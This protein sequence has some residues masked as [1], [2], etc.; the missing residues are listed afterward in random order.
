MRRFRVSSSAFRVRAAE[1]TR[2]S[3]LETRN[4][5]VLILLLLS[6]ICCRQEM[7]DQPKYKDL[8]RSEFFGDKRQARPVPEG[9]VARGFLRADSRVFAG[10]DP[11]G[12]LVTA[13]PMAVDQSLLLRGRQRYDIFCSPCHDRVGT[14][15]GMVVRRG[16]RPPPSLHIARLREAPVG[17]LFDVI[18]N[19]FGAMP[20]YSTQID[21]P[22]RW[23]IVAY[24]RALQLSE[25]APAAELPAEERA[26]LESAPAQGAPPL[27]LPTPA[28]APFPIS[29]RAGEGA[30]R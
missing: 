13:F 21:V 6:P 12:A 7:Y 28:P 25:N 26:K 5:L 17:H 18:S 24:V 29:G 3:K 23:A 11:S 2:N 19:G 30:P 16:Y 14:G 4:W 20:D 27:P 15:D 1:Q 9:T 8:R 22:D 10:R